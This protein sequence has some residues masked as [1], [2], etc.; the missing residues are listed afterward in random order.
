MTN[1]VLPEK[2]FKNTVRK[3]DFGSV[4]VG[5]DA[6]LPFMNNE[7]KNSL[8]QLIAAEILI[9]VPDNY[10]EMLRKAWGEVV[11][12]PVEWAK[13]AANYGAELIAVKFNV[14]NSENPIAEIPNC[15]E[16]LNKILAAVSLPIFILGT[17]RPEI[18][19]KLLPELAKAASR[20]CTVG[21]VEE[22]TYKE[23]V[24][25]ILEN[26]HNVIARSPI[27]I[28]LAKQLNILL[29][30]AGLDAN[31]IL[32]DPNTG[33]LGYGLDYAYSIIERIKLAGLEGDNML[34]MPIISFV[35]EES[36]KSK[37]AKSS[38]VP[39]EWGNLETRSIIWE[40]STASSLL[41]AGANIVVLYHP[42]SIKQVKN[43]IDNN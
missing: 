9:N 7:N 22:D 32:I 27:D 3:V 29:T 34:N 4:S 43:F 5:M 2:K 18:D 37:E 12:Y 6:S 10:P 41:V 16:I 1:F 15:V 42:E 40:C 17:E 33:A 31:K 23:I 39:Q 13:S 36:W 8:K 38:N 35:C 11:N 25:S 20:P 26:G 30:D 21:V 28:N 24:S 19:V 14:L